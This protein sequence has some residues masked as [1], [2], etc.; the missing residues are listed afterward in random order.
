MEGSYFLK[1]QEKKSFEL[2]NSTILL[3]E[4]ITTTNV[5]SLSLLLNIVGFCISLFLP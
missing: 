1:S 5:R 2:F 3:G 4:I